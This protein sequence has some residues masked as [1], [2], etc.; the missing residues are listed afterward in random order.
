MNAFAGVA[1]TNLLVRYLMRD[2]PPEQTAAVVALFEESLPR[3]LCVPA[4]VVAELTWVLKWHYKST[5]SE[6]A[7]AILTLID[8]PCLE[9]QKTTLDAIQ[10]YAEV[11]GGSVDFADCLVAATSQQERLPAITYDEDF[12]RFNDVRTLTALQLLE[13]L[14]SARA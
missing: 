10:L 8:V 14:R 11:K 12:R 2:E 7:A 1:D 3:S 13:Q 5:R 9:M 4:V 6:I